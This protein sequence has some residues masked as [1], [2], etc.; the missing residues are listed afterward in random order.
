MLLLGEQRHDRCEQFA[1]VNSLTVTRQRRDCYLIP[2]TSVPESSTISTRLP[3][4]PLLTL[5]KCFSA[6]L[7]RQS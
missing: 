1:R 2:G 5:T 7:R 6:K 3:S 4:H